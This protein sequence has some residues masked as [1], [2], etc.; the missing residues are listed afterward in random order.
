MNYIQIQQKNL[1]IYR[2]KWYDEQNGICPLLGTQI[3]FQDTSVDHT[4]KKRGD[5]VGLNGGGLIRGVIHFSANSLE[6]R[7]TNAFKRAGLNK[8]TD[9]PNFLRRLADYLENPPL[10]Y[11]Y[12]HPDEKDKPL[13]LKKRS[14]NKLNRRYKK[15]Y[16]NRKSLKYPKRKY[17]T[18]DLQRYFI[19]F[20]IVPEYYKELK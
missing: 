11:V 14:F 17:I 4:H 19:Q 10:G 20:K 7:I 5:P 15:K 16:P 6:G 3:P 12:I 8:F 1:K 18:K 9:L 2:K 13:K